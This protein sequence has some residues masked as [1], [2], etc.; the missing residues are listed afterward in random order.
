M[1]PQFLPGFTATVTFFSDIFKGGLT[2]SGVSS[3]VVS[4]VFNNLVIPC[5]TGCTQAQISQYTTGY[6]ITGALPGTAYFF[7][8]YGTRN[9][10]N[11]QVQGLDLSAS[12]EFQTDY[13]SFTL[14]EQATEFT[15]FMEN[16]GGGPEFNALNT[17]GL[18]VTFPSVQLQ[19]RG[20]LG[21]SMDSE[22][23]DL[24]VNYTGAYRNMSATAV[25]PVVQNA[26]GVPIGGGDHVSSNLTF[27][28]H[29]SY[30]FAA[31]ALAGDEIYVSVNNIAGTRPPFYNQA[32]G[33]DYFVANPLGRVVSVGLKAAF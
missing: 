19:T 7:V 31:D 20:H 15:K 28:V 23:V 3:D 1:A 12:Y 5:P 4:P 2:S 11:M 25:N 16:F 26:L 13:G 33:Y 32:Q 8:L 14:G 10:I 9:V 30:T 21:W 22:A 27:D 24:F 6:P 18:N 29:A 17:E